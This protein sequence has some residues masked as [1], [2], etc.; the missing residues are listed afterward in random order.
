MNAVNASTS[1]VDPAADAPD[2]SAVAPV[3]IVRPASTPSNGTRDGEVLQDTRVPP[4]TRSSSSSGALPPQYAD[5]P[6]QYANQPQYYPQQPHYVAP[7]HYGAPP[8]GAPYYNAPV[9]QQYG[10]YDG[11]GTP[12]VL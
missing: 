3:Q 7:N 8:Y 9:P 11:Y 5:Q 2:G 12:V 4:P 6:Q 1:E 10:Y